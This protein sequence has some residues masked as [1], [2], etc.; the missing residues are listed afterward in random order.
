M[1]TDLSTDWLYFDAKKSPEKISYKSSLTWKHKK[2]KKEL[3]KV[4]ICW[5]GSLESGEARQ[6]TTL[7]FKILEI[8]L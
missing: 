3:S 5:E 1:Q 8:H 2:D 7:F 4:V 6:E